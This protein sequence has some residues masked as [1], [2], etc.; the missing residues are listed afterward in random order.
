MLQWYYT[1]ELPVFYYKKYL[2]QLDSL[3]KLDDQDQVKLLLEK[4]KQDGLPTVDDKDLIDAIREGRE[5]A[6]REVSANFVEVQKLLR[7]QFGYDEDYLGREFNDDDQKRID[8]HYTMLQRQFGSD[9]LEFYSI[10]RGV[11]QHKEPSFSECYTKP[12]RNS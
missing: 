5:H 11:E 8:R 7:K 9:P 10:A 4:I 2:S 3:K 1:E 6:F 12:T